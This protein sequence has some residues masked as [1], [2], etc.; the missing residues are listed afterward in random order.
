MRLYEPDEGAI[1]IDGVDLRSGSLRSWR[2]QLG[3]V[4]QDSFLFDATLRENIALGRPGATDAEIQA[5]AAAAEV[6]GFVATRI[7]P[8]VNARG[9][10]SREPCCGTPGFSCWTR[11]PRPSTRPPSGRSTTH[12]VESLSAAP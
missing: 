12:C 11:P 3:V 2:E 7:C 9:L 10:P 8:A 4:F 5:A 6:D 1:L